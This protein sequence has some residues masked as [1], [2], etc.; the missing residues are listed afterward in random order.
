MLVL[1]PSMV[2]IS[3]VRFMR[4]IASARSRPWTINLAIIE[5]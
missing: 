3:S 5:S 2:V 1:M 4:A